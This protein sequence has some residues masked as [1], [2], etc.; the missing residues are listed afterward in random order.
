MYWKIL[1]LN[2]QSQCSSLQYNIATKIIEV[3]FKKFVSK[4]IWIT[5]VFDFLTQL[6]A[7][8]STLGTQMK[9]TKNLHLLSSLWIHLV[10]LN[11]NEYICIAFLLHFF[12]E[13]DK[14][15]VVK[16][17]NIY[18]LNVTFPKYNGIWHFEGRIP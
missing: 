12:A 15:G 9:Q 11:N 2:G 4:V 14:V 7:T 18:K 17:D 1:L 5:S 8:W 3:F 6:N 10:N 16:Y 13:L